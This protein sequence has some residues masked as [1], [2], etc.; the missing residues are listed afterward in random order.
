M[1][2]QN[3]KL[4]NYEENSLI[5]QEAMNQIKK[6]NRFTTYLEDNIPYW[7]ILYAQKRT[8]DP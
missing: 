5:F 3:L 8:T 7:I 2:C 6:Q 1:I 4:Q